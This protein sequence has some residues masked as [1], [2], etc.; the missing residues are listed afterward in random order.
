[1]DATSRPRLEVLEAALGIHFEDERHLQ[2]ALTHS[3]YL[4]EETP[5]S[6]GEESNERLEFLGDA[7]LGMVIAHR[8]FELAPEAPEGTLTA[9]RSHVVRRSAL[10]AAATRMGLG[11]FLVMGR[12]ERSAGGTTRASNLADAF[13]AVV[14]AV[15][16]DQG[17]AVAR[18]FALRWLEP[19][20]G[21]ALSAESSKDPKSELQERMQAVG[22]PLP[23]YR[24]VSEDGADP[25][26]RFSV[27]VVVNGRTAGTGTGRRKVDAERKAAREALATLPDPVNP[28][29]P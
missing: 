23:E 1:M 2:I 21:A 8:L 29:N 26:N 5:S 22:A 9:V 17:Y 24:T 3:S 15:M 13:E 10:S 12:G 25:D 16:L 4:N 28:A 19:E 7:V 14:G 20:I 18:E 27:E 11:D 6:E